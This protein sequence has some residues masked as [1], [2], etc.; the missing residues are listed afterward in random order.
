MARAPEADVGAARDENLDELGV[1][2]VRG[3]HQRSVRVLAHAHI[4]LVD[5]RAGVEECARDLKLLVAARP[6]VAAPAELDEKVL[7]VW[8]VGVACEPPNIITRPGRLSTR[9]RAGM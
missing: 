1:V 5:A 6:T 4:D 2:L 3:I 8:V 9:L 7:L